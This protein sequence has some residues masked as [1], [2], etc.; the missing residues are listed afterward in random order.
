MKMIPEQRLG[1]LLSLLGLLLAINLGA[2]STRPPDRVDN[3]H[4]T[5]GLANVTMPASKT[6]WNS[7]TGTAAFH[8]SN[9]SISGTTKMS[10]NSKQ[11]S[12]TT[13]ISHNSTQNGIVSKWNATIATTSSTYISV[14]TI[15]SNSTQ[16]T[17]VLVDSELVTGSTAPSQTTKLT[18]AMTPPVTTASVS[19]ATFKATNPP[20]TSPTTQRAK[21]PGIVSPHDNPTIASTLGFPKVLSTTLGTPFKLKHSKKTMTIILSSLLG[22][23]ALVIF[24]YTLDRCK[25]KKTQYLHRPL[26]NNSE[27]TVDRFLPADDTL[28]ISGGLYDGPRVYNPTMTTTNEDEDFHCDQPPFSSRSTQFQL[29]LLKE[30]GE[31]PPSSEASAFQTSQRMAED[32]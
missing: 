3:T 28:V 11:D 21:A 32:A 23:A 5:T 27:D 30:E 12:V 25:R 4:N 19:A 31:K 7:S 1:Q 15:S 18:T 9:Q 14:D 20:S 24:L 22:V 26:Y 13:A 8:G 10:P 16:D 6:N 17:Q 2:T 29:Q